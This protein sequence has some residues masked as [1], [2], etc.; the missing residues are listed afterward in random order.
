MDKL[1]KTLEPRGP[2]AQGH[3]QVPNAKSYIGG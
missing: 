3:G 1:V 2:D